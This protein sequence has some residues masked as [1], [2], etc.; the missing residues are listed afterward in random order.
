M[1]KL[2]ILDL[3]LSFFITLTNNYLHLIAV[4]KYLWVLEYIALGNND[5]KLVVQK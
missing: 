3:M 2:H 4:H 1:F 5:N